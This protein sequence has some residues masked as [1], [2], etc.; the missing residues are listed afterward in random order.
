MTQNVLPILDQHMFGNT[1]VALR[2]ARSLVL[3]QLLCLNN[4][5]H[6]GN[7]CWAPSLVNP[8]ALARQ[9]SSASRQ[10][11]NT[12]VFHLSD[13]TLQQIV[14]AEGKILRYG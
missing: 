7:I 2:S 9:R 8:R 4:S 3:K 10:N 6:S 12:P 5:A 13:T 14:E 1:A 11:T